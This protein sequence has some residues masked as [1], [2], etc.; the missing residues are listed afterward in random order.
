MKRLPANDL[1]A[2]CAKAEARVSKIV[3][4]KEFKEM[5]RDFLQRTMGRRF[6]DYVEAMESCASDLEYDRDHPAGSG[7]PWGEERIG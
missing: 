3:G 5:R 6:R 4:A 7:D 2:R 1:D